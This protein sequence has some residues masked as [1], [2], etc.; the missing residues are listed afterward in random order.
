MTEINK[1]ELERYY[2]IRDNNTGEYL[3][4]KPDSDGLGLIEVNDSTQ[5]TL[6]LVMTKEQARLLVDAMYEYI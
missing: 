1:F 2:R 5:P 3:T 6:R 4:V